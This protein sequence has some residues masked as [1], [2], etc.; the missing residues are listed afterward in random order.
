MQT[1]R[2]CCML[3]IELARDIYD[4]ILTVLSQLKFLTWMR[5]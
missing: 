3:E 4:Y 5:R 2:E 1:R